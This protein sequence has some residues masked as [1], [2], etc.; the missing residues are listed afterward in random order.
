MRFHAFLSCALIGICLG[1]AP[2][3]AVFKFAR[4]KKLAVDVASDAGPQTI[5]LVDINN[6]THADILVVDRSNNVVKVY[7][8]DGNG[9]FPTNPTSSPGTGPGPVAVATGDFNNDGKLDLVSVNN[10]AGTV[11]VQLGNGDG[12]FM[13][14]NGI[15]PR[16]YQV[17]PAP[18]G[19]AVEDFDNDSKLDLA[20]LSGA[21]IHLWKGN[22]DG[23]FVN[24]PTASIATGGGTNG[25]ANM[26]M[27]GLM[28]A[29]AFPD[30]V[31]SNHDARRVTVLLSNGNGTF[32]TPLPKSVNDYPMAISIADLNGDTKQD[33]AVALEGQSAPDFN[34]QILYGNGDGTFAS[35]SPNLTT[36]LEGPT[37]LVVDDFDADGK[38]DMA[39]TDVASGSGLSLLCN[40]QG[41][42]LDT[43]IANPVEAG[44]QLQA[45]FVGVGDAVAI[46]SGKINAD[47]YPDI[48]TLSADGTVLDVIINTT[49]GAQPTPTTPGAGVPTPTPSVPPTATA[50]VATPTPTLTLTPVPTPTP[51]PIPTA[52]YG[53]CNTNQPG[54]PAVG[55]KPVAVVTGDFYHDGNLDIAVADNQGNKVVLLR[56]NIATGA[57]SPCAVLGLTRSTELQNIAAPVALAAA[58]FDRDGKLDLAVVGSAG[59]S[60]FFGDG[61][62]GFG[63]I[64]TNPMPAGTS[65]NSLAV[66]DFNGDTWPDIVVANVSSNDVSIFFNKRQKDQP[67]FDSPCTVAVGRNA[68]QVIAR[69]LNGD[70]KPDF[71]VTSQ[72]TNDVVVF[73]QSV[74]SGTPSVPT[75]PTATVTFTS[76]PAVKLPQQPQAIA[77]DDFDQT[78]RSRPGFAVALS[79]NVIG[80]DGTVRVFLASSSSGGLSY[81]S[82]GTFTVTSPAGAQFTSS[83]SA[84]GTGDVNHDGRPDLIVTDQANGTVVIF[85][86]N[87]NG[88]FANALI[89]FAINGQQPV[90]LAVAD[91]D[92]DGIPDVVTANQGDGSVSVMVSSR[93]PATPTPLPTLTPTITGTPTPTSTPTETGTPTPTGTPTA[94]ITWTPLPT[95]TA[96]PSP[97]PTATLKPG[98]IGLQGSCT[99]DPYAPVD[100]T[101]AAF[102][103]AA[104]LAFAWRS[105]ILRRTTDG[106]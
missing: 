39:V 88:S 1:A 73:L 18:V 38:P 23:T 60:V 78:N 53:V 45:F 59:L 101:W 27:T 74:S 62:G 48:I 13:I 25:G 3:A 37:A 8:N 34:V 2:A 40:E 43:G 55:G 50:I 94:T 104:A 76:L 79:S 100:W 32:R 99:L 102:S 63:A 20:V 96:V 64:S 65:P 68:S 7:L 80:A 97:V 52:P 30:L 51:T 61:N 82:A 44:F 5:A 36:A 42:C 106:L 70:L 86:A 11:T 56:S 6:D 46:A 26:I 83:P 31:V 58:D 49:G 9:G 4:A 54:Q 16:D 19:V 71:A 29:G 103:T 35:G 84:L 90:D 17:D 24:F 66:A 57:L 89:P 75:C 72:Q 85:L 81:G 92:G 69:D 98:A 105:R 22:G 12:T 21:T 41:N 28:D 77:F 15:S 10:S 93:P 14:R 47:V 67:A 91:I 95:L 33:V 87:G